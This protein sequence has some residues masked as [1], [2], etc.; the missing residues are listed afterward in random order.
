MWG[1]RRFHRFLYLRISS[2]G[3][4]QTSPSH[5]TR[6]NERI[7]QEV[8]AITRDACELAVQNFRKCLQQCVAAKAAIWRTLFSKIK[9]CKIV[10]TAELENKNSYSLHYSVNFL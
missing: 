9:E 5:P 3:S 10:F 1:G 6:A 2:E 7:I 4:V 8:N